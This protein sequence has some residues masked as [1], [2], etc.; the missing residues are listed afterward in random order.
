MS[1]NITF[2]LGNAYQQIP[3]DGFSCQIFIMSVTAV[4]YFSHLLSRTNFM[5]LSVKLLII[6]IIK[7]TVGVMY[8]HNV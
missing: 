7:S 5:L 4:N 3:T 1:H 6:M 2:T 8:H